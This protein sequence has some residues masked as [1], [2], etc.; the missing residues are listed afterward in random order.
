MT[1]AARA[2]QAAAL[3]ELRCRVE[4]RALRH[5]VRNALVAMTANVEYLGDLGVEP[6]VLRE[7][8]GSLAQLV[9]LTRSPPAPAAEAPTEALAEWL[10]AVAP[11]ATIEVEGPNP[12][13][14][15]WLAVRWCSVLEGVQ[16]VLLKGSTL[17]VVC[18]PAPAGAA[19]RALL[20]G[21]RTVGADTT[22]VGSSLSA[23]LD[24]D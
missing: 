5:D 21:G 9:A 17:V 14:L 23:T 12:S 3:G 13:A 16:R 4:S 8:E 20:D 15:R 19:A 10:A 22:L 1:T 2:A 7:L 18:D 11:G 6:A 24:E